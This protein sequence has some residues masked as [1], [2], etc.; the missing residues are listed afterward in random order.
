MIVPPTDSSTVEGV[1]SVPAGGE[2][3][4]RPLRILT[5]VGSLRRN[6][7]NRRLALAAKSLAPPG[8]EVV[9]WERLAELPHYNEEL[10][11][12]PG[13]AVEELRAEARRADAL[14]FVTPEYNGAPPS[15]LKNAIDWL[16]RPA[17]A[18]PIAGK[19]AAVTGGSVS[20]F[21]AL[22]AQQVARRALMI[23]GAR[24]LERELPVGKID[25]R[26]SG[27]ELADEATAQALRELLR[28][29]AEAARSDDTEPVAAHTAPGR[30]E[31]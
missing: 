30:R 20:S 12:A 2:A 15:A 14:L 18:A 24:P 29:L 8:V 25:Q 6:S 11:H 13:P 17:G 21:G 28:E 9:L 22:W 31:A 27:E 26:F 4:G 7:W 1:R 19:P 16:S 10:E 3:A 23:A 5:L